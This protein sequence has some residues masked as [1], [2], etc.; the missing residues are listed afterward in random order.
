MLNTDFECKT[1]MFFVSTAIRP[2]TEFVGT[3]ISLSILFTP[4]VFPPIPDC[5]AAPAAPIPPISA[6]LSTGLGGG[7][8]GVDIC[9]VT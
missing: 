7:V 2:G 6:G 4:E 5:K 3:S 9:L 8:T 1:C